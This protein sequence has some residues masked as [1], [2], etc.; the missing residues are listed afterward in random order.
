MHTL[1][2]DLSEDEVSVR[3]TD[4]IGTL[5][6]ANAGAYTEVTLQVYVYQTRCE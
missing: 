1:S 5:S 6:S 4:L 2:Y 3:T